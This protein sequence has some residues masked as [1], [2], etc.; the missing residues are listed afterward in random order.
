MLRILCSTPL[1]HFYGQREE[2]R[3][4]QQQS[5]S[6]PPQISPE[7]LKHG[8][9]RS[10]LM[11][12]NV[13]EWYHWDTTSRHIIPH[14]T[15]SHVVIWHHIIS[16]RIAPYQITTHHIISRHTISHHTAPPCYAIACYL[17]CGDAHSSAL[18]NPILLY[19]DPFYPTLSYPISS[20][21]VSSLLYSKRANNN[22]TQPNID[23]I[24]S[25]K[26][27]KKN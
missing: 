24:S 25:Y 6:Q 21:P 19:A 13:M 26:I 7:K 8:M 20:Y 11:W 15:I 1:R 27:K 3:I 16:P 4:Q 14:H 12:W 23:I 5:F 22:W 2:E 9:N 18:S 17:F 10:D